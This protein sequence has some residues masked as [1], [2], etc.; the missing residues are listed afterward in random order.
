MKTTENTERWRP[1]TTEGRRTKRKSAE[2]LTFS[3]TFIITDFV[4][5][6]IVLDLWVYFGL[7]DVLFWMLQVVGITTVILLLVYWKHNR[8]LEKHRTKQILVQGGPW[9][10]VL[11]LFVVVAGTVAAYSATEDWGRPL[12]LLFTTTSFALYGTYVG[13]LYIFSP[14]GRLWFPP[15]EEQHVVEH[16]DDLDPI[17]HNDLRI[18]NMETDT[19]SITHRVESYTLESAL[20]GALAFSGFL[21]LLAADDPVLPKIEA[22]RQDIE[23]VWTA[24]RPQPLEALQAQMQSGDELELQ[25]G[26]WVQAGWNLAPLLVL[27]AVSDERRGREKL[28]RSEAALAALLVLAAS[29][30]RLL[31]KFGGSREVQ[32]FEQPPRHLCEPASPDPLLPAAWRPAAPLQ[33]ATMHPRCGTWPSNPRDRCHTTKRPCACSAPARRVCRP[34]HAGTRPARPSHRERPESDRG[35]PC[36]PE[37]VPAPPRRC[38]FGAPSAG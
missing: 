34:R 10:L 13:V 15:P 24:L 11:V 1:R 6:L 7:S 27:A 18:A 12:R 5:R 22:L 19:F 4:L 21:T 25:V 32:V 8:L 23:A 28:A 33:P 26:S 9:A 35:Q 36:G 30:G 38:R 20:F 17:D 37:G 14:S 29:L 3:A 2:R 31:G 16:A